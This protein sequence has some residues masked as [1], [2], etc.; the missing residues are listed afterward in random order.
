MEKVI[1]LIYRFKENDYQINLMDFD[2]HDQSI[3]MNMMEKYDDDSTCI[4]GD[5]MLN[6]GSANVDFFES[7][8]TKQDAEAKRIALAEKLYEV[9]M[10]ETNILYDYQAD[11]QLTIE[12]LADVLENKKDTAYMLETFLQFCDGSQEEEDHMKF[13]DAAMSIVRYMEDME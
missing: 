1:G 4:R 10:K 11:E 6:I 9:G 2:K 12:H 8:W 13:F 7:K 5:R 3:L